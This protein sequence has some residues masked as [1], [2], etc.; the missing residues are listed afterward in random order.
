[1]SHYC[2]DGR[3]AVCVPALWVLTVSG[4]FTIVELQQI[5]F[6]NRY[7]ISNIVE[8]ALHVLYAFVELTL[9]VL[10]VI[11]ELACIQIIAKIRIYER[12]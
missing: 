9:H 12:R 5:S 1:M 2:S 4:H 8:L 7:I 6:L 10:Y 3:Y 11:V